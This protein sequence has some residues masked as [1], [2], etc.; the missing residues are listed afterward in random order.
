MNFTVVVKCLQLIVA[1]KILIISYFE[2]EAGGSQ[3]QNHLEKLIET[4]SQI[5]SKKGARDIAQW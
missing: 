5:K 1:R 2:A 4:L 3:A